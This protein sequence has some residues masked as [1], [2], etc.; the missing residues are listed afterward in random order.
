MQVLLDDLLIWEGVVQQA[1]GKPVFALSSSNNN[2]SNSRDNSISVRSKFSQTI[3]F[4]NN[5]ELL[6]RENRTVASTM[7][8]TANAR[9]IPAEQVCQ[10]E[11]SELSFDFCS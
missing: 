4:V 3:F 2:N 5:E 11:H 10:S 1:P 6:Q 8:A 7:S 9:L